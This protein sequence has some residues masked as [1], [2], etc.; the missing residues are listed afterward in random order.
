MENNQTDPNKKGTQANQRPNEDPNRK[1]PEQKGP[2]EKK[3]ETDPEVPNLNVKKTGNPD[4][5]RMNR[6]AG[7]ENEDID[8]KGVVE[9]NDTHHEEKTDPDS[10]NKE[11]SN[12]VTM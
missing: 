10:Q 2:A 4:D 11:R 3:A 8:T 5:V 6:D 7:K 1:Q 9:E 12:K